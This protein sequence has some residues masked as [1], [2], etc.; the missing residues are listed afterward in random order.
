MPGAS[1]SSRTTPTISPKV[2]SQLTRLLYRS[3]GFGLFSNIFAAAV[4]ASAVSGEVGPTRAA[5]WLA[6]VLVLTAARYALNVAYFRSAPRP[7]QELN[8]LRAF[9]C[10]STG[11]GL[12]WG[13]AVWVFW[14]P[15]DIVS[16]C[17]L[18]FILAGLAAGAARSLA[19][20]PL[21]YGL[22]VAGTFGSL[23]IKFIT[24]PANGGL[25]LAA[26]TL[27][28]V[29][30]LLNT[31]RLHHADLKKLYQ[32]NY[33]NEDLIEN[34]KRA[35][36]RAD[37]ASQAKSEFLAMM[38]HEIRTPMNAVLGMMQLID[39]PNL[40]EEQRAQLYIAQTSASGLLKLLSDILDLSKIESGVME[41]EKTSVSLP[42][43][44]E[45][46]AELL[47][48]AAQ[49]KGIAFEVYHDPTLPAWV[50]ADATRLKQILINVLGNAV[51]FTVAGGAWLDVVVV[52]CADN[53]A[54]VEFRVRDTGI[55]MPP[56]LT[57][58]LFQVFSQG[59][60]RLARQYGGSGLGLAI[61]QKL[62]VQMG[63]QMTV[64]STEGVGSEFSFT[65]RFE[66]AAPPAAE[67]PAAPAPEQLRGR[68]LVVEDDPINQRVVQMMLNRLGV[69]VAIADNGVQGVD[70][71]VDEP[72]DAVL[73]DIQ[74]PGIDG[75]EATRRIRARLRG[76][77]LPIIALTANALAS[78]RTA[79][80]AA[81]MDEFLTKP[82]QKGE[83]ARCLDRWLSPN[84]QPAAVRK[85]V[86]SRDGA[87]L[88]SCP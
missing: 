85:P 42:R 51:K 78:N 15:T 29:A 49:K 86:V 56:Q 79:C 59:D 43:L 45:E 17:L 22:Y 70:R 36:D 1:S 5:V 23:L 35:K 14:S 26:A 50:M 32:L 4:L 21:G 19:P 20:S 3:A 84:A 8:W 60:S 18:I 64:K 73:M 38:S 71:A 48:P 6:I 61:A 13:A 37:R 69:E 30:F 83:L 12:L 76:K 81:G 53:E 39:R 75:I 40:T 25:F 52:Q 68:V 16:R 27:M 88:A 63:G 33:T 47:R 46:V 74:M 34:L 67:S 58:R 7:E 11:S 77:P 2:R 87:E 65:L 24:D 54:K 82:V 10:G 41:L 55:G 9:V 28:Y 66:L 57:R 44:T 80:F 62:L 31:A 72:W